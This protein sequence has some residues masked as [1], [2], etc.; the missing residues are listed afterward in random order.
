MSMNKRKFKIGELYRVGLD[1]F[2]DRM[3]ETGNIIRIKA[4]EYIYNN[5]MVRYQTVNQMVAI[6]CFIFIAVL[7]TV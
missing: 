4:I 6:V 1:S 3:T 2:G 5:K 7:L